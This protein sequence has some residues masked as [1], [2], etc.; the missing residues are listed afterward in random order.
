MI[1]YIIGYSP[2]YLA[3]IYLA[4]KIGKAKRLEKE[5]LFLQ[6]RKDKHA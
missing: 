1:D 3:L 4:I 2:V 5:I 6:E